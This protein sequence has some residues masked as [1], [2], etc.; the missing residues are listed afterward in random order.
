MRVRGWQETPPPL[1]ELPPRGLLSLQDGVLEL[2]A[3]KFMLY[4]DAGKKVT[5][6]KTKQLQLGEDDALQVGG[7]DVEV[8]TPIAESDYL[9][10]TAFMVSL[11]SPFEPRR[12][13]VEKLRIVTLGLA[14][15]CRKWPLN[16]PKRPH[17]RV[18]RVHVSTILE[19]EIGGRR[20]MAP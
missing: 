18:A 4:N 13:A 7:W 2:R 9:R 5:E 17:V 12:T 15:G 1:T 20:E 8:D 16:D 3:G 19:S 11:S 6:T 14:R 10:G